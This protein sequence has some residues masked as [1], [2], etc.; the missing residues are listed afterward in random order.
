MNYGL[1]YFEIKN[2]FRNKF[3]YSA[4]LDGFSLYEE[5]SSHL[6]M[7]KLIAP[8]DRIE[9][10]ETPENVFPSS[11]RAREA[12]KWESQVFKYE[13]EVFQNCPDELHK[14]LNSNSNIEA[15]TKVLE[16]FNM[17]KKSELEKMA[18]SSLLS[19]V[20][21]QSELEQLENDYLELLDENDETEVEY[22]E[23]LLQEEAV[24]KEIE[25]ATKEKEAVEKEQE[26][27]KKKQEAVTKEIEAVTKMLE[28]GERLER[29]LFLKMCEEGEFVEMELDKDNFYVPVQ[30]NNRN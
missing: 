19:Y 13:G 22:Q 20:R 25:A 16:G 17:N 1:N 8:F 26:A 28:Q 27:V 23:L 6:G 21:D 5:D 30:R 2:C 10:F 14:L 24:T 29:E 11:E 18:G 3:H 9:V 12:Y 4:D 15:L 7:L